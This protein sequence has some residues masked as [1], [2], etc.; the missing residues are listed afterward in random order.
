MNNL[1]TLS[2]LF[3]DKIFRIPDYQRGYAWQE[4]QWEEFWDDLINLS[5]DRE[6]YTGVITLKENSKEN[7]SVN[8]VPYKGYDIV[9]GQ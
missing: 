8:D 3:K 7:Q 6:H 2:D 5:D 1:K 9:D 4:K